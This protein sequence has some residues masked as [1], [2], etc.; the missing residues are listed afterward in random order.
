[1]A[2]KGNPVAIF[3]RERQVLERLNHYLLVI[4][5][6]PL[7]KAAGGALEQDLSEAALRTAVDRKFYTDVFE[8]DGRHDQLQ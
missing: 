1:M 3:E 6:P 7:H 2:D 5:P 8:D 4:S